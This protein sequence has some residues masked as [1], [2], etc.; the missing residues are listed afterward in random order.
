MLR[1][2]SLIIR[3]PGAVE[4]TTRDAHLPGLHLAQPGAGGAVGLHLLDPH[5][6]ADDEQPHVSADIGGAG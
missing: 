3:E 6:P 5:D 1:S 4:R 2:P